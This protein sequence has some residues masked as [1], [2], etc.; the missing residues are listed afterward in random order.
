M[1]V[2]QYVLVPVQEGEFCRPAQVLSEQEAVLQSF[3]S[4]IKSSRGCERDGLASQNCGV[5]CKLIN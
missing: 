4:E 3:L 2:L 5:V 1:E